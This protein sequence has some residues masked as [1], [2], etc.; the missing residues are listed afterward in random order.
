LADYIL[1]ID[2][3]GPAAVALA[4]PPDNLQQLPGPVQLGWNAAAD[5]LSGVKGYE[6]ELS[7]NAGFTSLVY[8][9]VLDTTGYTTGA[10]GQGNYFWRVRAGDGAG[11]WGP[12][13]QVGVF[14]VRKPI[15]ATPQTSAGVGIS[16]PLVLV[17]VAVILVAVIA[18][19]AMAARRKKKEPPVETMPP[20]AGP[21]VK[22]E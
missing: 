22:W 3:A 1:L 21:L 2:T 11:N 8:D 20:D 18:G 4:T 6:L 9:G 14:T 10:L 17:V 12:Y 7:D 19:I 15:P 13:S 5:A 16:N